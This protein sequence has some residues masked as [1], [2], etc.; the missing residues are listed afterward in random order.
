MTMGNDK[1]IFLAAQVIAEEGAVMN[2]YR[3]QTGPTPR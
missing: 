3:P 2:A 1:D